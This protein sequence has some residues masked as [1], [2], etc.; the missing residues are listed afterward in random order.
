MILKRSTK[1][2]CKSRDIERLEANPRRGATLPKSLAALC[3]MCWTV[4][5]LWLIFLSSY[6]VRI[7]RSHAP[8][9]PRRDV[10]SSKTAIDFHSYASRVNP[11]PRLAGGVGWY[12][13][14]LVQFSYF[15]YI[16]ILTRV[17]FKYTYY[18]CGSTTSA[19]RNL[20]TKNSPKLYRGSMPCLVY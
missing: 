1:F 16:S 14:N 6:V 18:K 20:L 12:R 7:R 4:N 3:V 8:Q 13:T 15:S 19:S 2:D 17:D 9:Y 10:Q 5:V 11:T